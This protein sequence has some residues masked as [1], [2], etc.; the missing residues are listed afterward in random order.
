MLKELEAVDG[1]YNAF[2]AYKK[3]GIAASH[4]ANSN[5]DAWGVVSYYIAKRKGIL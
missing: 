2:A 4:W 1:Y 3:A 5:P